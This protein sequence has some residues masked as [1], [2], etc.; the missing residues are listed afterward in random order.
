MTHADEPRPGI[1]GLARQLVGGVVQLVRL[2][3]THGRQEIGEMLAETRLGALLLALAAV[4]IVIALVTMDIVVVLGVAALF[5]VLPDL[6]AVI[7]ILAAFVALIVLYGAFG[8]VS[9]A[10]RGPWYVT[11]L[12]LLVMVG[13]A[14]GFVLPTYL[15]FRAA[16]LSALFVFSMQLAVAPLF[17]MRGVRHVRIGPPERTIESVKE[18]IAWAKRLLKR[19]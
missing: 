11:A 9:F 12:A 14:A 5:E 13:L 17:I 6:T 15:G 1:F 19:G 16:W 10:A 8:G 7:I 3:L 2:E 18:D 4:F